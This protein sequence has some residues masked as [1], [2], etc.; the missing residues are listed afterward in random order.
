MAAKTPSPRLGKQQLKQEDKKTESMS[1]AS[2]SKSG[3]DWPELPSS[4]PAGSR[5]VSVA[6]SST[7]SPW[8]NSPWRKATPE[9]SPVVKLPS[10]DLAQPAQSTTPEPDQDCVSVTHEV[11]APTT[12]RKIV[13]AQ[14]TDSSTVEHFPSFSTIHDTQTPTSFDHITPDLDHASQL[15]EVHHPTPVRNLSQETI[16]AINKVPEKVEKTSATS[17]IT[18]EDWETTA[19]GPDQEVNLTATSASEKA[20]LNALSPAFDP[21]FEPRSRGNRAASVTSADGIYPMRE[22]PKA[23]YTSNLH[24]LVSPS[25]RIACPTPQFPGHLVNLGPPVPPAHPPNILYPFYNQYPPNSFVYSPYHAPM[26]GPPLPPPVPMAAPQLHHPD[27]PPHSPQHARSSSMSVIDASSLIR[28]FQNDPQGT[29]ERLQARSRLAD[30]LGVENDALKHANDRFKVD[31]EELNKH[32]SDLEDKL[33]TAEKNHTDARKM[34][35]TLQA[36]EYNKAKQVEMLI[37]EVNR[38]NH[39]VRNRDPSWPLR[40]L[41]L[42]ARLIQDIHLEDVA[43]AATSAR[44]GPEAEVNLPCFMCNA[45]GHMSDGK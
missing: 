28:H 32:N 11:E 22:A 42:P 23:P 18:S 9:Q 44:F 13:P 38:L 45:M 40:Q 16:E 2:G 17:G 3:E 27:P 31:V 37:T 26:P 1:R 39:E 29:A 35:K 41:P 21:Y 30:Q 10:P 4:K 19:A 12:A 8:A 33:A 24:S 5:N 36:L 15:L 43:V 34:V 25:I 7:S 6:Q 20:P 14:E